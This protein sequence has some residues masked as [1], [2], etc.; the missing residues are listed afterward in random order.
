[1]L[2]LF[3]GLSLIALLAL[4]FYRLFYRKLQDSEERFRLIFNLMPYACSINDMD[5]RFRMVNQA[6]CIKSER[7]EEDI[8]GKNN[9]EMGDVIDPEASKKIRD[10]ILEKGRVENQKIQMY[11]NGKEFHLMFSSALV[12]IHGEKCFISS[13]IDIT[14]QVH[15]EEALRE[16]EARYQSVLTVSNT[17]AWEYH[18]DRN[19][20]WCS[21]MYFEI[22]GL[23]PG[24]FIMDGRENLTEVWL[25]L[26]HPEDREGAQETFSRYLASGCAG[27]YENTFRMRHR[28]GKWIWIFSRGQ[29]LRDADHR[30]GNRIVGTHINITDIKEAQQ[31]IVEKNRE[32]EQIVYVTS[33]D[34]RSPLVNVDGYGRELDYSV[35]ALE[36]ALADSAVQDMLQ[37]SLT[38][39]LPAMKEA[40]GH[41]RNSTRQMD[42]LLKGLLRLS[43]TGRA[44]LSIETVNMEA[45]M[46]TLVS[47]FEFQVKTTGARIEVG[48]LPPCRGDAVQLGQVFSNLISNALKYLE[49][50]RPGRIEILGFQQEGQCLYRV[51]DNGIGIDPRH[52]EKVFEIFHRLNPAA[53]E[54]EGLGL[55]IVR[56]ILGRLDGEVRL[57]SRPGEGASFEVR[58]PAAMNSQVNASEKGSS[59]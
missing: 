24:N 32:L 41:I 3:S 35:Q 40:L 45:L 12:N 49:P 11:R 52:Q 25:N 15:A 59:P 33:H 39:E 9:Q 44:R 10:A 34:L 23:D 27:M 14:E 26:L 20:V 6:Y 5:G 53:T 51:K 42:S 16:S 19:H 4:L 46:G 38:A 56:Q 50:G 1:M 18:R 17:G 8:L 37:N 36:T 58:L 21:P 55:T 7:R 43:R 28:N 30:A 2:P 54:G 47:S 13:T 57:S 29:A 22:L 31:L 48:P